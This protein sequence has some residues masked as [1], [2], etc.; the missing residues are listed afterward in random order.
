MPA[1]TTAVTEA[2]IAEAAFHLW[3]TEGRP[4]GRAEDHWYRAM[5]S[6]KAQATPRAPAKAR[7][8]KPAAAKAAAPKAKAAKSKAV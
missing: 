7:T 2:Q 6:L 4:E 5:T 3:E 8:A 1:A